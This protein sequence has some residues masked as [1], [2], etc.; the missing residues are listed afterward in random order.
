MARTESKSP[1]RNS[2]QVL[3]AYVPMVRYIADIIGPRCEV[4]LH[5]VKDPSNSIVAIRNGYISGRSIGGPMTDLG[6]KLIEASPHMDEEALINYG[7]KTSY[8]DKLV[9]ST[10][11]IR[12]DAG[13][14]TGLLCVNILKDGM[15]SSPSFLSGVEAHMMQDH[16]SQD[17][18]T[19]VNELLSTSPDQVIRQAVES[20]LEH[21]E[22]SVDRL[23]FEEKKDMIYRLQKNGIFKIKGAVTQV[24]AML[25]IADSTVYR[26]LSSIK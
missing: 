3:Q 13:V 16:L 12:D 26:Y 4:V 8:G 19:M 18:E 7:S 17:K 15:P 21:G 14:L 9:S 11:F 22:I 25:G 10:Y 2:Q 20:V 5:D 23:T 1:A 6:L 24:G